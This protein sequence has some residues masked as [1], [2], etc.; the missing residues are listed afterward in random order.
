MNA[1]TPNATNNEQQL[2]RRIKEIERQ[3]QSFPVRNVG[4][5]AIPVNWVRID[6]G[7]ELNA[8]PSILGIKTGSLPATLP[9]DLDPG[10]VDPGTGS[11]TTAPTGT[12]PDG[13]G[14]GSLITPG[15]GYERVLVRWT[16]ARAALASWRYLAVSRITIPDDDTPAGSKSL[17]TVLE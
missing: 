9:A 2:N 10:A 6:G 16:G 1:L 3:V 8:A 12:F 14:Y 5:G 17:W 13:V 15:G 4:G 11:Q 7:Q